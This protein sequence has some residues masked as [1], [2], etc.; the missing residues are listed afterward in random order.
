MPVDSSSPAWLPIT[1]ASPKP[2]R[3]RRNGKK[4]AQSGVSSRSHG[5]PKVQLER[6]RLDVKQLETELARLKSESAQQPN[7]SPGAWSTTSYSN[8]GGSVDAVMWRAVAL[9]QY[10]RRNQSEQTRQK[11]KQVLA[12]QI[13]L[14]KALEALILRPTTQDVSPFVK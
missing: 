2:K 1:E 6:L 9:R 11:L 14:A 12:K 3:Q 5:N 13:K 8:D 10:Q 7:S 4:Q